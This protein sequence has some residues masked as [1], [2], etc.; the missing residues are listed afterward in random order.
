[1]SNAKFDTAK[2]WFEKLRD[3]L[4]NSLE[5]FRYIKNLLL[6]NGIINQKVVVK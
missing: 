5:S 6:L 3:K 2:E 1:M 4:I